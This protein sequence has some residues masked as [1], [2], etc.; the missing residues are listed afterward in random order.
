MIHLITDEFGNYVKGF[1]EHSGIPLTTA[2]VE[3]ARYFE[4]QVAEQIVEL[5]PNLSLTNG[6]NRSEWE[7]EKRDISL[8]LTR[9]NVFS[10]RKLDTID[11]YNSEAISS[12]EYATQM[13]YCN[14]QLEEVR[15][16][17]LGLI[18]L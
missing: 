6:F 1:C 16:L 5:R 18:Q 2:H 8:A 14:E 11:Q 9:L 15:E 17:V 13:R 10:R 3:F 4:K 12:D 7:S